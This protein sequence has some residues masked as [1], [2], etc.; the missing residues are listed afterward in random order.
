MKSYPACKKTKKSQLYP[1]HITGTDVT[2]NSLHPGLIKTELGRHFHISK[3]FPLWK[4]IMMYPVWHLVF[5]TPVQ[6]AQTTIHCAVAEDLEVVS[7]K[8]FR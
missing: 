7:G 2:V 6:G 3:P 8:Y 4:L 1:L 5:K